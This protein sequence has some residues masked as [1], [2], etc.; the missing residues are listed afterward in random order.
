MGRRGKKQNSSAKVSSEPGL[1]VLKYL[2][3]PSP[4]HPPSATPPQ[5]QGEKKGGR[6]ILLYLASS[7]M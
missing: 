4:L 3:S 1:A 6:K 2:S 5:E 7:G